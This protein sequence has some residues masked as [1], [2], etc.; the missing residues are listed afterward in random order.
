MWS[1]MSEVC[2]LARC[3]LGLSA[4]FADTARQMDQETEAAISS[5][6]SIRASADGPVKLKS[7]GLYVWR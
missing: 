1:T 5:T 2:P 3:V 7:M 6:C 4:P